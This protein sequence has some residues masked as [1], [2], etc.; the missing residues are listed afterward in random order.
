MTVRCWLRFSFLFLLFLFAL[1]IRDRFQSV[2]RLQ[3]TLAFGANFVFP[4]RIFVVLVP[5]RFLSAEPNIISATD[6]VRWIIIKGVGSA[7]VESEVDAV[8]FEGHRISRSFLEL[9]ALELLDCDLVVAVSDLE[10]PELHFAPVLGVR[11]P[12]APRFVAARPGFV[13]Q[14]CEYLECP[15]EPGPLF[16]FLLFSGFLGILTQQRSRGAVASH[17]LLERE[18]APFARIGPLLSRKRVVFHENGQSHHRRD[19]DPPIFFRER[20]GQNPLNDHRDSIIYTLRTNPN[21]RFTE[22]M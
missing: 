19:S 14:T 6:S 22:D 18:R 15:H 9:F 8:T 16:V 20:D 4:V 17:L 11:V 13:C 7:L 10:D 21:A 5:F 3:L 12:E 1:Q 2:H